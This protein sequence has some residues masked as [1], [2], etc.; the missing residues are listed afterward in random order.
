[1]EFNQLN[2]GKQSTE[3]CVK[4]YELKLQESKENLEKSELKN[5]L[6]EESQKDLLNKLSSL[7]NSV[8]SKQEEI[9]TLSEKINNIRVELTSEN[10]RTMKQLECSKKELKEFEEKINNEI[11]KYKK[12]GDLVKEYEIKQNNLNDKVELYLKYLNI[13]KDMFD[14]KDFFENN[15]EDLL[16]NQINNFKNESEKKCLLWN[17][18]KER[19]SSELNSKSDLIKNLTNEL[20]E[21]KKE[22]AKKANENEVRLFYPTISVKSLIEYFFKGY[23]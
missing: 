6:L 19:L 4:S 5:K 7:E 9:K 12:M 20:S 11:E 8:S 3:E 21:L 13:V 14:F 18:D 2:D 1:M 23:Y 10:D 17:E 15:N 22:S 16:I